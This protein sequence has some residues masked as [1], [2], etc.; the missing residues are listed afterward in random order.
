NPDFSQVEADEG[1]VTVNERFALFVTEKRPFFL[2]GIDR[3]STP[4][5][6]V[7]TRR[8]VN[9]LVGGKFT[10][11]VGSLNAAHL[12]ALDED[13]D[14]ARRDALFNIMRVRRDLGSSS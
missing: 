9:P 1:Q 8:I 14:D 12:T 4:N 2:E 5:Q 7:Y 13:I 3:F 6:L 10:G 11:K